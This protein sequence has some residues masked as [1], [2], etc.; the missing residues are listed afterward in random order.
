VV[1]GIGEPL[2]MPELLAKYEKLARAKQGNQGNGALLFR[3]SA[4]WARLA[5]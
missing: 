1:V 5:L 2:R 4:S 3:L